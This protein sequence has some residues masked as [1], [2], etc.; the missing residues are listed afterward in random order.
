M[1]AV[2]D[3]IG[4]G[5]SVTRQP[6]ARIAQ[7]IREALG[8]ARTVLNVGAGTGSYEPAGLQVVAVEPSYAMIQQRPASAA[9]V[10]QAVAEHLPWAD[11]AFDATL[12]I[13]TIHHWPNRA[14]GLTE[15]RRVA[16]HRVVLLTWDP[17]C[18]DA[19]WLINQYIPQILALD[20]PRFPS[21]AELSRCLGRIEVRPVPIPYDCQDG[22]LGAF[23]RR[24]ESYLD[25]NVQRAISGF[26][27]LPPE[28]VNAGLARLTEDLRSGQWE[29]RFGWMRTQT[30][31][32][33]GY[34]LIIALF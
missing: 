19:F 34:R 12:A 7:V 9:P 21:M 2:Y 8:E 16:R 4:R 13:L 27:Q 17:A 11:A 33:L 30:S 1:S 10:V 28:V 18:R 23:W 24:P 22:F 31:L 26:A 5:Y 15:L 6:D 29:T 3:E 14:A 20:V 25:P 32:D